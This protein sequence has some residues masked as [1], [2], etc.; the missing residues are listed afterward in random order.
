ME[1]QRFSDFMQE[2]FLFLSCF[3][4][5]E[6]CMCSIFYL[7]GL[8]TYR[9]FCLLVHQLWIFNLLLLV[10]EQIFTG[11]HYLERII[12][13]P[14]YIKEIGNKV[15]HNLLLFPC[16][17]MIVQFGRPNIGN[18]QLKETSFGASWFIW[19]LTNNVMIVVLQKKGKITDE[20]C[21]IE[22]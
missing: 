6:I 15:P 11:R 10:T 3:L 1:A 21:S 7:I 2:P 19:I 18:K 9:W 5:G 14:C 8:N 16:C 12:E 20:E 4:A 17:T 13:S 22:H